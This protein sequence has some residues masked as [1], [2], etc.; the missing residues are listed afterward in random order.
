V[1]YLKIVKN[2]IANGPGVRLSIFVPGCDIHCPGCFNK[3]TWSFDQGEVLNT[4]EVFADFS[5]NPL[6]S[7]IS[8]LGGDPM[9]DKNIHNTLEFCRSFKEKFPDKTIWVWTGHLYEDLSMIRE[10]KETEH[11]IDVLV[12]GPFID[13]EKDEGLLYIGSKNQRILQYS[14]DRG[15]ILWN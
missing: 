6:Y 7:G 12:D 8:L 5:A 1:K 11:L 10:F 4:E 2:D 15:R 9:A 14:A 13:E 3:E